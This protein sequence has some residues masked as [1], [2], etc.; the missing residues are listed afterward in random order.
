ML[1]ASTDTQIRLLKSPAYSRPHISSLTTFRFIAAL[2]IFILHARDHNLISDAILFG[3]DLSQAVT[4]FFVLSG[5]IISYAYSGRSIK[6]ITF[7]RARLARVWPAFLLSIVFVLLLL[8]RSLYLPAVN[9]LWHT[10]IA[11]VVTAL[12]FQAWVP[13]PSIFFGF[14]AVTWSISVEFFFYF[15]FPFIQRIRTVGISLILGILIF[16]SILVAHLVSVNNVP[17]F[18]TALVNEV[19]SE[20]L[21]YINPLLRLPEFLLGV[22]AYRLFASN[23]FKSMNGCL[24]RCMSPDLAKVSNVL[25]VIS[26]GCFAYLAFRT[27]EFGMDLPLTLIFNRYL[28]SI[29]FCFLILTLSICQGSIGRFFSWPPFVFLGEISF[30]V[31]LYHQPLMILA[32]QGLGLKFAGIQILPLNPIAILG[33]TILLASSSY[34]FFERPLNA[35]LRPK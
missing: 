15:C 26:G 12:G 35:A 33:A 30:G 25:F 21:I 6:S 17:S 5:F 20:G 8:P 22:M 3:L 4:F 9:N 27:L 18:S 1:F 32:V 11:F 19:V 14:N 29:N 23:L 10:L 2:A 31:Y 28:S 34:L 13:I 7:Y 24:Y 16:Y